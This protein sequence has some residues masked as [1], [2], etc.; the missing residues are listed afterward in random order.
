MSASRLSQALSKGHFVL[1]DDCVFLNPPGLIDVPVQRAVQGN[2]LEYQVLLSREVDISPELSGAASSAVVFCHRVKQVTLSMIAKVVTAVPEGGLIVV[3]GDKTA[4]VEG[5]LKALRSRFED[6]EAYAKAHGKTLWFTVPEPR[7]D[8]TD[9]Q[10]KTFTLSGEFETASG[11]FSA[12]K[13][14]RGSELLATHLPEFSGKIADLGAGWGYLARHVLRSQTVTQCDLVESDFATLEAAKHN[15]TD[16]RAQFFWADATK[17]EG[18]YDAV[19]SN[20]PF[21][22]SRRA[23]PGL[24]MAFLRQASRLLSPKG[25]LWIVANRSLPYEDVLDQSFSEI[26]ILAQTDGFKVIRAARP[27]KV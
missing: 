8:L 19:V 20:P 6:V 24:G 17:F 27:K 22:A 14:D 11:M 12:E 9:W 5:I 2:F 16:P 15:V 18:A 13:I 23:D 21:H 3:D 1:P 4:G 7:P 10:I 25:A 26:R